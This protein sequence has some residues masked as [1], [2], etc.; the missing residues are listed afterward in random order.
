MSWVEKINWAFFG[1]CSVELNKRV[2]DNVNK[3][4]KLA[5]SSSITNIPPSVR[6]SKIGPEILKTLLGYILINLFLCDEDEIK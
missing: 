3:G 2:I 6:T 5:S 1:L 4:C